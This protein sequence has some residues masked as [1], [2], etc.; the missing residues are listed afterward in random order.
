MKP[1]AVVGAG[2]SFSDLSQKYLKIVQN[3]DILV[4]GRRHL[5]WFEDHPGEK[6]EIEAPLSEVIAYIEQRMDQK[7]IAVI[8]SGDPLFY[9][10]GKVLTK[11][12][13]ADNVCIYPNISTLAACFAHLKMPWVRAA[14]V[15]LHGKDRFIELFDALR[16]DRPIFVLTDPRHN[17]AWL[18]G[19]IN[20]QGLTRWHMWVFECL[21]EPDERIR[22]FS[23]GEVPLAEVSEPNA[24]I[25]LGQFDH[26]KI[27][28]MVMGAPENWYEH[29]RGLIT[30]SEIRA[31]VLSR[32][33]LSRN[34]VFWDLGSG[35]GSVAI[36][37]AVFVTRGHIV[38]VEKNETRAAQIRTNAKNFGAG[39]IRV[40]VA[41]LPEGIEKFP[42]P[43]RVF[44]GGGGKD[45]GR[46]V[47]AASKRLR[48]GG[49]MVINAVLIENMAYALEMLKKLGFATEVVQ[50]QISRGEAISDGTRFSA[51]NPVWIISGER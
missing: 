6:R 24:V 48:P 12:L 47:D 23:P 25:I 3:A 36:E 42:A 49:R 37:A 46:I 10:I 9:G 1:V 33:R 11:A 27:Y 38:A 44:I 18:D 40:E 43:D 13:G 19:F 15:S 2:L 51:N 30:K 17:P 8:A 29:E 39:H 31:I 34:H 35:S 50:V 7:N 14:V 5:S 28:P 4:G 41:N 20:S 21:G 16:S 45:I 22:R 26:E 32:L